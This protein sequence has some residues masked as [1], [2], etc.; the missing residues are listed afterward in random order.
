MVSKFL[1][2]LQTH[3]KLEDGGDFTLILDM[4]KVIY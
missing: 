1:T 4:Q 3:L 2:Q